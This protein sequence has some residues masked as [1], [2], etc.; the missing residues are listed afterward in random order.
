MKAYLLD[1]M[2]VL[3]MTFLP[4]KLGAEAAK[5]LQTEEPSLWYSAA[6]IWEIGIRMSIGGYQDLALPGDWNHHLITELEKQRIHCLEIAPKYCQALQELDQHHRDPF[7]RMMIAQAKTEN[8]IIIGSDQKFD[9][10]EV[11]R[12]WD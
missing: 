6:A 5:I 8:L 10:Y 12:I 7:D 4:K 1:T 2:T 3:R 9:Q 11:P